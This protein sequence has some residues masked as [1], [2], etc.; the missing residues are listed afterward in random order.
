MHFAVYLSSDDDLV[1]I[2]EVPQSPSENLLTRADRID[3]GGIEKIDPQLQ[4]FLDDRPAVFFIQYP[5]MN[6]PCR[7]AEPH[8]AQADARYIHSGVSELRVVHV[9]F[10]SFHQLFYA[11]GTSFSVVARACEAIIG[12]TYVALYLWYFA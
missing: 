12:S 10:L 11:D 4:G 2:G 6:P 7:V 9:I 3:I 8:A 1:P 5:L